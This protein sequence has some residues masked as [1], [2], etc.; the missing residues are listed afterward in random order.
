MKIL[1]LQKED[2]I[3]L[4]SAKHNGFVDGYSLDE[5]N[6]SFDTD[7]LLGF[8][9]KE[10]DQRIGFIIYTLTDFDADIDSVFVLESFRKGGVG[11]ELVKAVIDV[12]IKKRLEQVFLEVRKSNTPAINL[13]KSQGFIEFSV[14]KKYYF[15]GEDAVCMKKELKV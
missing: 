3:F 2:L 5:L 7:R 15:D 10:K 4:A 12:A 9:A 14:R 8:I 1:P 13:Y 6:R 11:K